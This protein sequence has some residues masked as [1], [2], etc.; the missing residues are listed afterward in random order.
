MLADMTI[1]PFRI[2]ERAAPGGGRL[3]LCRLPGRTGDLP[4]DVGV[5]ADWAPALVV[6]L[7]ETAEMVRYGASGLADRLHAVG[8][9]HLHWPIRDFGVPDR[10]EPGWPVL[11]ALLHA[12]L[13]A[14]EGVL[15]HCLGG[16]GRSGMVAMRLLVERGMPPEAALAAVR[17]VRPQAVETEPQRRW[18]AEGPSPRD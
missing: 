5:I 7:T 2:F 13:D 9:A 3:G 8:L 18:A 15:V 16:Q 14:G 17:A 4:G 11:A 6:S 1:E 12:R 10:A